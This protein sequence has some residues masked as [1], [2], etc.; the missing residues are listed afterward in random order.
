VRKPRWHWA[1]R[2]VNPHNY[3]EAKTLIRILRNNYGVT[4]AP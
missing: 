4:E 1:T 3:A 2:S